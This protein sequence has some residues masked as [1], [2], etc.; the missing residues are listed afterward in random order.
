[1]KIRPVVPTIVQPAGRFTLTSATTP[2]VTSQSTSAC[3]R[4]NDTC[5]DDTFVTLTVRAVVVAK[6]LPRRLLRGKTPPKSP[7]IGARSPV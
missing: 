4:Q 7:V 6:Q 5:Q 3:T 2:T 1:M